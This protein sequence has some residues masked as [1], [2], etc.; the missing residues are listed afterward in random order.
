M[1]W[2]AGTPACGPADLRA[3]RTARANHCQ[4]IGLNGEEQYT[5]AFVVDIGDQE[6]RLGHDPE[7]SS[8]DTILVGVE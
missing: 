2:T 8:G 3:K 6:P 4:W 7:V 1:D 5:F